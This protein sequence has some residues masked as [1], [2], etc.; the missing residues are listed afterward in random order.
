VSNYRLARFL[1][2]PVSAYLGKISY[3]FYLWN[4]L[5][6][7]VVFALR[8]YFPASW[9]AHPVEAGVITAI[10]IIAA[11]I[12]VADVSS[13]FIEAPGNRVGHLLS[14]SLLRLTPAV[15]ARLSR[16]I[17]IASSRNGTENQAT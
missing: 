9:P 4:V 1:S 6:L 16:Q 5:F 8:A 7:N 13:R 3:S 15:F 11:T 17:H 14:G 10:L 2:G 12:P